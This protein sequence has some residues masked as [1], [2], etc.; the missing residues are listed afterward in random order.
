MNEDK[1]GICVDNS[2]AIKIDGIALNSVE[3]P[4]YLHGADIG[5]INPDALETVS[6]E[7]PFWHWLRGKW[8]RLV[9][10]FFP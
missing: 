3:H 2:H 10:R 9:K 4:V 8:R 5:E 1:W 6:I 7:I